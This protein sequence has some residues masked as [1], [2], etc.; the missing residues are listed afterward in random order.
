MWRLDLVDIVIINIKGI[1]FGC[2]ICSIGKSE[3]IPLLE[4]SVIENRMYKLQIKE[5]NIKNRVCNYYFEN[6]IKAKHFKPIK[7]F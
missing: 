6:L 5:V 3:A 2:I 7:L 4:N 1:H